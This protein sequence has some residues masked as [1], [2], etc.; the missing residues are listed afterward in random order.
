MGYAFDNYSLT[1]RMSKVISV[2]WCASC[3]SKKAT[4]QAKPLEKRSFR[5]VREAVEGI[6]SWPDCR[7][8]KALAGRD[9]YR[10]RVG[11]NRVLFAVREGK[12]R[13]I[14]IEEVKK[15]DERTY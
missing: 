8:V 1:E 2:V 12:M 6:L 3:W 14:F 11:R 5:A 7:N 10:V 9:G 15:R 4:K 13:I